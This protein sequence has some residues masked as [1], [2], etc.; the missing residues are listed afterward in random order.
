MKNPI[1]D[2]EYDDPREFVESL[3]SSY[4]ATKTQQYQLSEDELESGTDSQDEDRDGS[5]DDHECGINPLGEE[6]FR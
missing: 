2:Q 5:Q 3:I 6:R 4:I 1:T